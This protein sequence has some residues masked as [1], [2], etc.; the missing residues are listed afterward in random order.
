MVKGWRPKFLLVESPIPSNPIGFCV[1]RL[2]KVEN[3]VLKAR[4][5]DVLEGL[6]KNRY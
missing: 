5:L 6:A 1:M 4:G 2:V 3:C